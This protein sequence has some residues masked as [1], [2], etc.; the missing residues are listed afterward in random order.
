MTNVIPACGFRTNMMLCDYIYIYMMFILESKASGIQA[1]CQ[2]RIFNYLTQ[3][4]N[5][6]S[7]LEANSPNVTLWQTY[8]KLLNM[9]IEIVDLPI[10][11]GGS[12]HIVTLVYRR[13][14]DDICWFNMMDGLNRFDD[15]LHHF[16]VIN[17]AL[18]IP[19]ISKPWGLP[20]DDQKPLTHV[21]A[22]LWRAL[23]GGWIQQCLGHGCVGCVL[24][25][26]AFI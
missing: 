13:V 25:F 8:K 6:W 7:L 17:Q 16:N 4:S 21:T 10:Q 19:R 26:G 12:F 11:N 9:A 3:Q 1:K 22:E 2:A 5:R 24:N 15:I 18:L 14:Y 20:W 23:P